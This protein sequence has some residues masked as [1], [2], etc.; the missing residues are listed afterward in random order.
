[1]T[2]G[3]EQAGGKPAAFLPFIFNCNDSF[4][5]LNYLFPTTACSQDF[6]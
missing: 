1:M 5:T 6:I 2:E 3:I 4:S